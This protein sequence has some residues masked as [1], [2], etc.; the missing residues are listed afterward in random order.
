MNKLRQMSVF[1]H[2]VE[3]GSITA[4]AEY[5]GLSKSVVSQH[6]KAL[7]DELGLSLLKRT[8]RRQSL[9]SAGRGFYERCRELNSLVDVAWQEAREQKQIP[10][11]IVRLTAPEALMSRIVIPAVVPLMQRYT[12][13]RVDMLSSDQHLSLIDDDIDVAIRVGPS[14]ESSLKQRRIGA[15]RDV[16]CASRGLLE[17]WLSDD[18]RLSDT[19]RIPYIANTWQPPVIEHQMTNPEGEKFTFSSS[20]CSRANSFNTVLELIKHGGGVGIVPDF[21]FRENTLSLGPVYP[22]FSTELNTVYAL[23]PYTSHLPLSVDLVIESI[24][25]QFEKIGLSADAP[26]PEAD[27]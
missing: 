11:G 3:K 16:L 7:E 22:G 12:K 23:H 14:P 18:S 19:L 25:R 26:L 6:L 15:F 1:A 2:L 24:E 13:L 20:N 21:V 17:K 27:K 4:A 10:Q 5:L 8:T 9:T